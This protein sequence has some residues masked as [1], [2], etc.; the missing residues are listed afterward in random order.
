V[1]GTPGGTFSA[2]TMSWRDFDMMSTDPWK[3]PGSLMC[4]LFSFRRAEAKFHL[5]NNVNMA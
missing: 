4:S 2:I 5:Q 3:A 1:I